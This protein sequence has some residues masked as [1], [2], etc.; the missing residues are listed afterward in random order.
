MPIYNASLLA[1]DPKETRRYAGLAKAH[2]FDEAM[3]AEACEDALLLAEPRGSW[4]VYD[5]I[6]GSASVCVEPPFALAGASIARHLS[7]C[8][9]V[10]FL[11]ATVGEGIEQ[12]SSRRFGAGGYASA[13]LLDAG[14][15]AAVEQVADAMEDAIRPGILR[16]GYRMRWRFS[17]GYGDWPLSQQPDVLR[18][19]GGERIGISLT[20]SLM[21]MPR[22]SITAVIGLARNEKA[23]SEERVENGTPKGC[24]ACGMRDCPSRR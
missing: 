8:D 14:A 7:G 16:E 9:R 5:Y 12:E 18:L 20:D 19:S 2:S 23:S 17:P 15:T 3:I 24:A 22:K 6:C 11:A 10:I 1:V 13:V 4:E 21:L